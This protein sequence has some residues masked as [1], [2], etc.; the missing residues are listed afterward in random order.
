MK[1][2]PLFLSLAMFAAWNSAA[3]ATTYTFNGTT[4]DAWNTDTNWSSSAIAPGTGSSVTRVNINATALYDLGTTATYTGTT[5]SAEGRSIVIGNNDTGNSKLTVT[6]GTIVANGGDTSFVGGGQTNSYAG[7]AQLVLSGG[8][9]T[10]SGQFGVLTRGTAAAN[11]SVTVNSGST[12]TADV[13]SFGTFAG[14]AGS[15]SININ[16]GGVVETRTILETNNVTGTLQLNIDGGKLRASVTGT[17]QEWVRNTNV[18]PALRILSNGATF[19]ST[20]TVGE[21]RFTCA[22]VDGGSPA[23]DVRFTG[24][25]RFIIHADNTNTG[26]T[27]VD[28]G[29]TL[30]IGWGGGVGTLGSGQLVNNGTIALNRTT[31]LSQSAI[32]G[33]SGGLQS[34]FEQKGV[35]VLTLDV[36]NSNTGTTTVSTG[37]VRATNSGALSAGGIVSVKAGAQIALSGGVTIPKDIAVTGAGYT[38]TFT[39]TEILAG[40]RGA[41]SSSAG[42][43]TLNGAVSVTA[44]PVRIG[45]Q[46]GAS[47]VLNGAI[48]EAVAGCNVIFRGTTAGNG[49]ITLA[50]ANNHWTGTST[51]YGGSVVLGVDNGLSPNA[52]LNI[53]TNGVGTSILDLNGHAQELGGIV[54]DTVNKG[55][56][57]VQ[58]NAATDATL[59]LNNTADNTWDGIIQ[60]GATN[61]VKLVKKGTASQTLT[62][63]QTFT[64]ST[65]VQAGTLYLNAALASTQVSVGAAGTL[66]GFGSIAGSTTVAGVVSPGSTATTVGTLPTHDLSFNGGSYL[67]QLKAGTCDLLD[68]TG[69]L[70]LTN[71][72]LTTAVLQATTL[73]SYTVARYTGTRTGTFNPGALPSGFFIQY[74]D[75]NRTVN[76]VFGASPYTTWSQGLGM[77]PSGDGAPN[78]DYDH[79]GI[80]NAVEYVL[81]TDPKTASS[82]SFMTSSDGTNWTIAFIRNVNSETSDISLSVEASDN[83]STWQSFHVGVTTGDS[84]PGVSVITL[85]AQTEIITVTIPRGSGNRIFARLRVSAS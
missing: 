82:S 8:N 78:A 16:S 33:L 67:C 75:V 2:S 9:L 42:T 50:N 20:D 80:P 51:I 77:N 28:A 5:G 37:V 19:E 76:L 81:G 46:E 74:D 43:N 36:P 59:T 70:N 53:G 15:A 25:G 49:T 85:D 64:G 34:N 56:S 24:G 38:G 35:N 31:H 12:F 79:D 27:T 6:S 58:N 83:L 23:G 40:S 55:A 62:T 7:A 61:T 48:T 57:R 32:P 45:V 73:T 30:T 72:T 22:M 66:A 68:V 60:N 69:N 14:S 3:R 65:T 21:K 1:P 47:L 63:A 84:S 39:G 54:T 71:A 17:D 41:I 10:S 29:T 11:A 4:S 52:L 44:S 13:I 18:G 26:K